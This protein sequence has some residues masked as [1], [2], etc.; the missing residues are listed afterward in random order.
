MGWKFWGSRIFPLQPSLA[1]IGKQSMLSWSNEN[2]PTVQ[3]ENTK[4][5]GCLQDM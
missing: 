2:N 3:G 5:A 1:K 4:F